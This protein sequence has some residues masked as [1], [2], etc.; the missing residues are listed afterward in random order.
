MM[1]LGLLRKKRLRVDVL[2]KWKGTGSHSH[3]L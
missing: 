1:E 2:G 3:C